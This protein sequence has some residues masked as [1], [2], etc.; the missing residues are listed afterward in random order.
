MR[1]LDYARNDSKDAQDDIF[2][3]WVLNLAFKC[4]IIV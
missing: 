4:A 1:F 3:I 2:L